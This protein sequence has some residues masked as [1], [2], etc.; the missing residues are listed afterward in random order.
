MKTFLLWLC[1]ASAMS[2]LSVASPCGSTWCSAVY[3]YGTS[4]WSRCDASGCSGGDYKAAGS[5]CVEEY[6]HMPKVSYKWGKRASNR[7]D[8]VAG[9]LKSGLRCTVRDD[10]GL[11]NC[12]DTGFGHFSC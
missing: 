6:G 4:A 9:S 10:H 2:A 8:K 11:K 5:W 1:V 3:S 7:L 12:H